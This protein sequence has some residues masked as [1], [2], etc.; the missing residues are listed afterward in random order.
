MTRPSKKEQTDCC[1]VRVS[2]PYGD[3]ATQLAG[4]RGFTLMEMMIALVVGGMLMASLVGISASVQR[5]FGR[6]A[7]VTELQANLRFSMKTMVQDI[8]RAAFMYSPNAS[9]DFCHL[10]GAAISGDER[11]IRFTASPLSMTLR[12][13]F[14][15]S[16]DYLL[17]LEAN[18]YPV[19]CRNQQA[20]TAGGQCSLGATTASDVTH[21]RYLQ[22]FGDGPSIADVFPVNSWV[23]L[24]VDNR[25]YAYHQ[26]AT[27][28]PANFSV[29]FTQ[30][31]NR[32][33]VR[34]NHRW[35][36]PVSI[37]RWNLAQDG[38][39]VP[40][41]GSAAIP[42][43]GRW[44]LRRQFVDE[45]GNALR[46]AVEVAEFLLPLRADGMGGL[47]FQVVADSL[48][49]MCQMAVQ[50][51]LLA[52]A[53]M[54]TVDPVTARAVIVTMRGRTETED[55]G[56]FIDNYAGQVPAIYDKAIDLDGDSGNGLAMVATE[57]TVVNLRNLSLNQS[58]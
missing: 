4:R 20:W 14:A 21:E 9:N 18:P 10:S 40:R 51:N 54:T 2:N 41:F 8:S 49:S 37:L 56:F 11:A 33:V 35:I 16:R 27:V 1:K 17:N 55:P 23:R 39:Y 13:N 52:A 32:N 57:R 38:A 58:F 47:D 24:E 29:T 22:P 28:T 53:S 26:I 42:A 36:S 31:V 15:S 30:P 48:G 44:V 3:C 43:N 5:T 7:E 6:S 12:G 19:V 45:N 50:P 46:P 25:R 34:G